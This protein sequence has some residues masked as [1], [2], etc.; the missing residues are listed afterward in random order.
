[1]RLDDAFNIADL[2]ARA[3]RRLPRVVWDY[4]DGGAEDEVSLRENRA[5]FARYNFEPRVLAGAVHRDQSVTLFGRKLAS[6]FLIGP[7]GLNGLFW[8]DGDLALARA[9]AARGI[10]FVLSTASNNSL[11]VVSASCHGPRWFQLY[12]WGDAAFS[13]RLLDRARGAGYDAVVVTVDTLIAG[14]RERDLRNRFSH[15]VRVTPRVILDGIMHP[16]WLTSVWLRKGKPRFENLAEFLPPGASAAALADFTRS[17]RN[18]SFAWSD[19][20][21][22]KRSWGGPLIVKGVLSAA[23]ATFAREAGADGIVVSNH[24]GRQLD[25]APA[26]IDVV[27]DVAEAVPDLTILVDGGVR[28]GTDVVKAIGLGAD[29]VLLGRATLYGLAA[30]GEAGVGRALDILRDEVDRTLALVGVE[31]LGSLRVGRVVR[32]VWANTAAAR[33]ASTAAI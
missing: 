21:R 16:A 1:M 31:T 23:D 26:T 27:G 8:P 4:L 24:G 5:A 11:E 13:D 29:A 2:A 18:P 7:T 12:P 30:A 14:K 3:R 20:A 9:A 28:R 32:D 17:Q 25:G 15:E 19:V 33:A 10:G 22:L 6:P